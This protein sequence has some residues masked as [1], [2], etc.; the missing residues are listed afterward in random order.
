ML[1]R[2]CLRLGLEELERCL[3]VRFSFLSP[4]FLL[5]E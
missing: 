1:G 4:A 3:G 2:E 5:E